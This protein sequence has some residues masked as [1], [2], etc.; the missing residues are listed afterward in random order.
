[1]LNN[2]LR[3]KSISNAKKIKKNTLVITAAITAIPVN[4]R[5]A[6]MIANPKNA[7]IIAMMKKIPVNRII[8]Y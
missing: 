5:S 2:L 3:S 6:A 4:P 8:D 7:A 1:M